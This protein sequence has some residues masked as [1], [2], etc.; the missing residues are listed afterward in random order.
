M[1]ASTE[2]LTAYPVWDR[3]VRI[4]H[5][6]NVLC[7]IGLIFVG[8]AILNGKSLGVSGEGKIL[9]KTIHVYIGYVF[10]ANLLWR[11]VWMFMGNRFAK[12]GQILPFG[13]KYKASLKSFIQE[14]K[15]GNPPNYLGHNPIARL[16]VALLFVLLSA[17]VVTGMVL[18]STDLYFPPFGDSMKEW[19]AGENKENIALIQ[20]GSKEHVDPVAY[21]E[22]REFRKPYIQLHVFV[23]Y[24]LLFA[25][26]LHL[27]GVIAGEVKEKSGL[28]SAMISGNKFFTKKPVDLDE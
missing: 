25:I 2:Q 13:P 12:L 7:V 16:M 24:S 15:A 28:V 21:K 10:A 9:L 11:F 8:I 20:A 19:V 6:V 14:S 26:A 4:F 22:M 23:F 18:S 1:T 17:Q 5:W 27:L 3:G